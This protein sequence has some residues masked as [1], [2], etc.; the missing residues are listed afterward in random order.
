MG[1]PR[2]VKRL[3]E[4]TP[5]ARVDDV[6]ASSPTIVAGIDSAAMDLD[7]DLAFFDMN[8][9]SFLDLMGSDLEM[10]TSNHMG[11]PML[12][13]PVVQQP[14]PPGLLQGTIAEHPAQHI[15][16]DPR[17][18]LQ[19]LPGEFSPGQA[20]G[21]MTH[22]LPEDQRL[23]TLPAQPP[24]TTPSHP[25]RPDSDRPHICSCLAS[26]YL[27]LD[28]L[29]HLPKSASA[30][31][32][33]ARAACRTAYETISCP[34]CSM[35]PLDPSSPTDAPI[36]SVQNMMMLG[37]LLLSLSN[38]YRT[39]LRAVDEEAHAASL[40]SRRLTFDISSYGAR[41]PA[42]SDDSVPARQ[43]EPAAWRLTVRALLKLEVY[44]PSECAPGSEELGGHPLWQ[45]GLKDVVRMM[46]ERS[47]NRHE[48]L[49][50]LVREGVVRLE[51]Q[52][53]YV[54]LDNPRGEKPTCFR[55]IDV[56]KRSM[57]RLE[58]A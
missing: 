13:K 32:T 26:L 19:V 9:A 11:T 34:V 39:I 51:K 12:P 40:S 43:L 6:P 27:A 35:P 55:I 20:A 14:P 4:T 42:A 1:R 57:Q 8:D 31:I 10:G 38:A 49:D 47:R 28:S 33:T 41:P 16:F 23:S 17:P 44:G 29:Q 58:I 5:H 50:R 2:K 24:S 22:G 21:V 37:A 15:S 25:F 48:E 53:D 30:A 3:Q 18:E 54:P 36:Q 56:A 46:E 52:C 7:L 45:P